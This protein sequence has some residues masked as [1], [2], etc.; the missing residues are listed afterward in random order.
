MAV[1]VGTEVR[2][3]WVVGGDVLIAVGVDVD[4]VT[5]VVV[6]KRAMCGVVGLVMGVWVVAVVVVVEVWMGM[7]ET[8]WDGFDDDAEGVKWV[9]VDPCVVA[10]G[11][12]YVEVVVDV[13]GD[14]DEVGDDVNEDGWLDLDDVSEC[15]GAGDE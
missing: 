12:G 6:V 10:E 8:V 9:D 13:E 11:M 4:G 14:V 15:V 2:R 5:A 1:E 7:D 3:S